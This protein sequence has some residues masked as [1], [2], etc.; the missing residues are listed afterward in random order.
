M[1]GTN[2]ACSAAFLDYPAFERVIVRKQ[3]RAWMAVIGLERQ[4]RE[5]EQAEARAK[6]G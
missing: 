2:V 4:G 3:A 1:M 5:E 6:Q